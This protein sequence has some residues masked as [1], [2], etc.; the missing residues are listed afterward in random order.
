VIAISAGSPADIAAAVE[1]LGHHPSHKM[2]RE[3]PFGPGC[4]YCHANILTPI[5]R[6]QCSGQ[7]PN[8]YGSLNPTPGRRTWDILGSS[9]T[10]TVEERTDTRKGGTYL[11]C[12]CP[13]WKYHGQSCKH[14]DAASAEKWFGHA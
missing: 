10:W 8:P 14:T 6:A 1:L 13:A 5:G 9:R 11:Y 12:A 4:V 3:Q 7:E 2:E